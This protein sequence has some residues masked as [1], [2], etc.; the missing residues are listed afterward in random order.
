M[1]TIATWKDKKQ[2]WMAGDSGAFDESSVT[3]SSEPKVWK[4]NNSLVGVSGSFRI[5]DLLRRAGI[6]DP[7]KIRDFLLSKISEPGFPQE[8]D[9][10]V[11]VANKKGIYGI[12]SD[13]SVLKFRE[14]Y[15][16]SGAGGQAALAA[17]CVLEPNKEIL[18]K[19]R[20]ELVM[21]ATELHTTYSRPPFKII[22][23]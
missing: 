1:T 2:V 9:W 7:Y 8:S 15:G 16:A 5:M 12:A 3:L 19:T 23:L 22:S 21:K 17:L 11:I 6:D 20:M 10:E 4:A 14:N 13:F 18:P